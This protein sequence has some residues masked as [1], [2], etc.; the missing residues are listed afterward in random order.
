VLCDTRR[1]VDP[2][3]EANEILREKGYK[4]TWLAVFPTPMPTKVLIK[5]PRILSPFADSP[6]TVLRTV[7]ECVPTADE[8]GT[9]TLTPHELR[10]CL[11]R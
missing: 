7:R 5:G 6:E 3:D 2:I 10:D 9:R 8:L 4:E 1:A 11:A